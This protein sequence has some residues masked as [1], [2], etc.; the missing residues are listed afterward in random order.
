MSEAHVSFCCRFVVVLFFL[1][2]AACCGFVQTIQR[3]RAEDKKPTEAAFVMAFRA[4]HNLRQPD[5]ARELFEHRIEVGL[6]P[7]EYAHVKVSR[8]FHSVLLVGSAGNSSIDASPGSRP[9]EAVFISG[10]VAPQQGRRS[11]RRGH[12]N[13][14]TVNRLHGLL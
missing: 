3:M 11:S 2:L 7:R 13:V 9:A 10:G 6:P 5:T 14:R 1:L 4:A 8:T 12:K